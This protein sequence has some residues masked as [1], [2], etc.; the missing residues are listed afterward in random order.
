MAMSM[1]L[2]ERGSGMERSSSATCTAGPVVFVVADDVHARLSLAQPITATGLEVES[3]AAA[4]AFLLSRPEVPCCLV[5]DQPRRETPLALYRELQGR[6]DVP[7][8]CITRVADVRGTVEAMKA[9]AVDVLAR[10]VHPEQLLGAVQAAIV[11][12]RVAMARHAARTELRRCYASLTRREREVM[13]LVVSGL[14]NKQVAYELGISE[15]TVK[16]HRGQVM[17]KMNAGSLPHLV[18]MASRLDLAPPRDAAE[19]TH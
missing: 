8:I 13:Q 3:C 5:L 19:V 1:E 9:G 10:P 16:A 2:L 4:D 15:I 12:S 6:L 14:L 18:R 7:I 17:R 11:L